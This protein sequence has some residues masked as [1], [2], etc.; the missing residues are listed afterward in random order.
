MIFTNIAALVTMAGAVRQNKRS[1]FTEDD[2]G[3]IT[4]AWLA[5]GDGRIAA[6]GAGSPPDEYQSWPE[7]DLSGHMVLPGLVDSHTH[8]I[9][10]GARFDEFAMRLNGKSYQQIAAD[11][12]G[13][14]STIASTRQASRAELRDNTLK[15]LAKIG[16]SGVTTIECKTGYG[17]S[18][19]SELEQ[20]AILQELKASQPLQ[21]KAT[22]LGLHAQPPASGSK[23]EFIAAMTAVLPTIKSEGLADFVDAFVENGYFSVQD[24]ES[25]FA[26]AKEL[27]LSIR[28]H[29]DE[30]ADSG[31]A[32]AAARWGALSA[33]HLE[34]CSPEGAAAMA[35]AGTV[36]TLLPGTSLFTKIPYAKASLFREAGVGIAVATDFNPGSCLFHN[37]PFCCSIAAIHCG[38]SAA[39]A[40]AAVTWVPAQSL[41]LQSDTG[42]LTPGFRAD[43]LVHSAAGI[44]EWLAD[45]GQT[46]PAAV[47]FAGQN[48]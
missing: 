47:Y 43:F 17:Q 31:A 11:G 28:I 15:N 18:P 35:T 16:R 29:A 13:I 27:G 39:E 34:E 23:K 46:P 45:C 26:A 7:T 21:L 42:A 6:Y 10:A 8:P 33:D 4:D 44:A 12:G 14:Q 32:A 22:Y 9:F 5:V 20:L 1:G 48:I 25:Y 19:A 40:I 36:A 24:C 30:F 3:V 37:L 38:L 41:G 2:L